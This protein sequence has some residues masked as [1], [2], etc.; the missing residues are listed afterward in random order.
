MTE[1]KILPTAFTW[2]NGMMQPQSA[3][4]ARERYVEGETYILVPHTA[5]S[6]KSHNHYFACIKAAWD[7]LPEDIA[8][9][10]ASPDHLRK[11]ALIK[12]GWRDEQVIGCKDEADAKQM[13]TIIKSILRPLDDYAVVIPSDESVTV[14]T[15]K[16]QTLK[17]MGKDDFQKS[18]DDVFRVLSELLSVDISELTKNAGQAA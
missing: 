8:A 17:A 15:A 4:I 9:K 5:R 10:V 11:W 13:A 3:D 16:S 1:A 2:R 6:D 12:S 14:Y 7:N 18:K